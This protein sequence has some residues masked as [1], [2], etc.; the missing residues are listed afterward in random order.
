MSIVDELVTK[1]KNLYL[2]NNHKIV[3]RADAEEASRYDIHDA[4]DAM[5]EE[6]K[7]DEI[8]AICED[9]I[10]H[11]ADVVDDRWYDFGGMADQTFAGILREVCVAFFLNRLH[12]DPEVE[13]RLEK[14][15]IHDTAAELRAEEEGDTS[16]Q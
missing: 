16:E 5:M 10:V 4:V 7:S 2:Q 14:W 6:V 3:K 11:H 8:A 9:I 15:A 13:A 12:Q 1:A